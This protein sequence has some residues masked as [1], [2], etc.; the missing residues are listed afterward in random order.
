MDQGVVA[1]EKRPSEQVFQAEHTRMKEFLGK[2]N[3]M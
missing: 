1:L 2:L 3:G